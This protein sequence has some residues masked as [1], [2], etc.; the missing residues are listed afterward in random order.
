MKVHVLLPS[1]TEPL[2][3]ELAEML[4]DSLSRQGCEA[5]P[6]TDGDRSSLDARVVILFGECIRL[7]RSARALKGAGSLKPVT[8]LWQIEPFPP[9]GVPDHLLDRPARTR[10]EKSLWWLETTGAE[11]FRKVVPLRWRHRLK[12]ATRAAV[13]SRKAEDTGSAEDMLYWGVQRLERVSWIERATEEGWLDHVWVSAPER[14]RL[15]EERGIRSSFVPLG[16]H[17]QMGSDRGGVRDLDILFLGRIKDDRAVLLRFLQNELRP[18]GAT[19]M[20]EEGPCFGEDRTKLLNR[21]KMSLNLLGREKELARSRVL[22][23]IACGATV[24]SEPLDDPSPFVPGKHLVCASPGEMPSVIRHFLHH[25]QERR[26]IA[27]AAR[28]FV[29]TNMTMDGAAAQMI[30]LWGGGSAPAPVESDR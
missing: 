9:P 12:E 13:G 25:D 8:M 19:V 10:R 30:E 5:R 20:I 17:P 23:S 28:D 11:A 27:E 18:E 3:G 21:A 16:Y 4:V 22:L 2:I 1:P 29:S 15:L 7:P 26:K 14:A 24:I 6:F